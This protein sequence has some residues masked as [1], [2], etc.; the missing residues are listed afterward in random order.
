MNRK[1]GKDIVMLSTAVLTL[2]S[3]ITLAFLSFF[4]SLNHSIHSSVLWYFAQSL[5]YA[6]SAFGMVGY[7]NYKIDKISNALKS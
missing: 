2:C 5:L 4:L 6:A 3:G 1:D 7:V